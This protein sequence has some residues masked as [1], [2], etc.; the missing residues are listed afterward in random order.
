MLPNT[1][2]AK[3]YYDLP[4]PGYLRAAAIIPPAPIVGRRPGD[5]QD[6]LRGPQTDRPILTAREKEVVGVGVGPHLI[7]R[8]G[9]AG[10]RVHILLVVRGGTAGGDGERSID[11]TSSL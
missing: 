11:C 1:K 4:S 6:Q 2:S 7:H 5:V 3:D 10:E 9:M 8:P